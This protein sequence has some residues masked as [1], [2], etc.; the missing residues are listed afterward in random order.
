M[1]GIGGMGF[2]EEDNVGSPIDEEKKGNV[3]PTHLITLAVHHPDPQDQLLRIII[4]KDTVQIIPESQVNLLRDV[5]HSQLLVRHP[6]VV[7][8]D[9]EQPGDDV[10]HIE[11]RHLVV[12]VHP[13]LIL[14]DDRL[15]GVR[16]VVDSRVARHVTQGRVLESTQ[17][18][19]MMRFCWIKGIVK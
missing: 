12:H 15:L 4:V 9:P 14:G 6:L 19:V 11:I 16:V 13:I 17:D 10:G 2:S 18:L 1:P 7:Q 8:L 5:L 3:T